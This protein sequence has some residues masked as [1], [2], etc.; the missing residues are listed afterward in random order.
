MTS[1][2][3]SVSRVT[4]QKVRISLQN[5]VLNLAFVIQGFYLNTCHSLWLSS[6]ISKQKRPKCLMEIQLKAGTGCRMN[7]KENYKCLQT[8]TNCIL[9]ILFCLFFVIEN[10]FISANSNVYKFCISPL[11]LF[12]FVLLCFVLFRLNRLYGKHEYKI[13]ESNFS[14]RLQCCSTLQFLEFDI[15][16]ANVRKPSSN[17]FS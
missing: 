11:Y 6:C 2:L 5:K 8:W 17:I 12:F 14:I 1:S 3:T 13:C 16:N 7:V 15:N 10:I 9:C 4:I